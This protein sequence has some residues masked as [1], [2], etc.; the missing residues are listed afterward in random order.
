M[1][2]EA[3]KGRNHIMRGLALAIVYKYGDGAGRFG[4]EGLDMVLG[5]QRNESYV[6]TCVPY[7]VCPSVYQRMC[8]LNVSTQQFMLTCMKG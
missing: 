6:T 1:R 3:D 8:T 2:A 7:T 4:K 5:G